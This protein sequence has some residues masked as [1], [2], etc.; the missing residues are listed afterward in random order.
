MAYD[1]VNGMVYVMVYIMV[2]F[3]V[4]DMEYG[5]VYGMVY[6][7]RRR[8]GDEFRERRR[9]R[10]RGTGTTDLFYVHIWSREIWV[11]ERSCGPRGPERPTA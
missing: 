8:A 4:Y 11:R 3:M 10:G 6:V 5:M 7:A 1:M 2:Y 9:Q